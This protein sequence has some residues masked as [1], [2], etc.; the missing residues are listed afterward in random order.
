MAEESGSTSKI[1]ELA[2]S[3][4][5]RFR[6][7][8]RPAISDYTRRHPELTAQI[9]DVFPALVMLEQVQRD[10]QSS[11]T[12]PISSQ[13]PGA[14]ST[15]GDFRIIREVGRGGMGVVFEAEQ[16][17][18]GRQVALKVLSGSLLADSKL[19]KRFEREARSA[20]RLHH[21][22][23]VPVFGVG[24]Q[25]GVSYYVMQFIQG[26]GLDEV[27]AE[28]KKLPPQAVRS[29]ELLAA[30]QLQDA[31]AAG[32]A[33]HAVSAVHIADSLRRGQF[34]QTTLLPNG[35]L[36]DS[37]SE[38]SDFDEFGVTALPNQGLSAAAGHRDAVDTAV[39]HLSDTA[40][41]TRS[42]VLPGQSE[43]Q[44]GRNHGRNFYWQSIA[45]IG[46][47]VADALHYAHDQGVIHRDIKPANLLLDTRGTV[48]V[49]DF[50]LAKAIDQ[51]DLT[52]TG[53]VL[54]TL[55][56]M[57]PEQFDGRADARSDVYA[58][59]L[60]L[61][62]LLSLRPAFNEV[63][64]QK[65]IRQVSDGTPPRLRL[66]DPSIPR[67]LETIVHKAI[68][69]DPAHRY[70]A[71]GEMAADLQ[72]YLGDEPIRARRISPVA[73]F[74]RWCKRNP[75]GGAIV[76]LLVVGLGASIA[77]A[78]LLAN[79][80][81]RTEVALADS[82]EKSKQ[83]QAQNDELDKER[84]RAEENH[85]RAREAVDRLLTKVA[86]DLEDTPQ[87]EQIRRALLED[88]LEF[89]QV[90]LKQKGRDP[91]IRFETGLAFFRVA[92]IQRQLSRGPESIKDYEEATAI[93]QALADEFPKRTEYREQLAHCDL[94]RGTALSRM[95]RYDDA[96]AAYQKAIDAWEALVVELPR[97]PVCLEELARANYEMGHLWN[98]RYFFTKSGPYV[99]RSE[100]LLAQLAKEFPNYPVDPAVKLKVPDLLRATAQAR[101][102][103]PEA[104][105][106]NQSHYF[107]IL[108]H[109]SVG[110]ARYDQ[111]GREILM[112]WERLTEAHPDVPDYRKLFH[113][114]SADYGRVLMAMDRF[115]E[116][117][118][119]AWRNRDDIT[120]LVA[121]Y[122]DIPE[123]RV[124]LAWN[125]IDL[126]NLL[127]LGK[128]PA[129]ALEHFR[130]AIDLA[131]KLV[132]Q[133]PQEPRHK[134]HLA[135]MLNVCPA[136]QFQDPERVI[137]LLRQALQFDEN[138]REWTT[139]GFA[140][141]RAGR[142]TEALQ[143]YQ[144][145]RELGVKDAR[146]F[147]GEAFVYHHLGRPDDAR[148]SYQLAIDALDQTTNQFW[149]L[150]QLRLIRAELEGLL[151]I[152]AAETPETPNTPPMP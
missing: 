32:C 34:S 125:E 30:G 61:Y 26:L 111:E 134:I 15:L 82:E 84:Q 86:K 41:Y 9:Q 136:P 33:N 11:P 23:I 151:Q 137:A 72:R 94:R 36:S 73:R 83:L 35:H 58:L 98:R 133:H 69:R 54:G 95:Y 59:G 146:L 21:T 29:G 48:W 97:H 122:P 103:M 24:E 150:P 47:Q 3:F 18:L 108:P 67:D 46:V 107:W 53:D 65:L 104:I 51:H 135:G 102:E 123:Y 38:N 17:S 96:A 89:Y 49:T 70:Q 121:E 75:A 131:G 56:Y 129:E 12:I 92:D 126:G 101:G 117:E 141:T 64:R 44:S 2:E 127:H 77:A 28:L 62:E 74:A 91:T 116:A 149:Y 144:K 4:V 79:E 120:R 138:P 115:E 128:R 57:A 147:L 55:R 109:D 81:N 22:N 114:T 130:V 80:R 148:K 85:R 14:M 16:V 45:R 143:S 39:G 8:E 50:G 10:L 42:F 132:E 140:Q 142:N 87:M 124:G 7:G 118:Q 6:R 119:L 27:L 71:A 113:Q 152:G 66:L 145:A 99:A 88:A 112:H 1:E 93:F 63:E 110:L 40:P 25:D 60:T 37:G 68:D 106:R 5:E 43:Q 20:A 52:H 78:V 90:F 13:C 100:E 76:A 105:R 139:I 19:R 31:A